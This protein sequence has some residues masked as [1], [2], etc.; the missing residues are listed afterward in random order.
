MERAF[1]R[2]GTDSIISGHTR[3]KN[4][5]NAQCVVV[6]LISP[7][8]FRNTTEHIPVRNRINAVFVKRRLTVVA[9]Y[10]DT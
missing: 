10:N 8:I 2:L 6:V 1:L 3:A 5:T 4:R 9:I 7:V